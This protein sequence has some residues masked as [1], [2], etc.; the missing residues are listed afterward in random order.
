MTEP[1]CST[2]FAS[3]LSYVAIMQ[4]GVVDCV[5]VV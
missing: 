3:E 5:I 2:G 4:Q 1:K